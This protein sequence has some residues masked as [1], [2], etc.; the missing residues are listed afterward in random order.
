M[1]TDDI[2]RCLKKLRLNS[3]I[4]QMSEKIEAESNQEY[5][6]K[7][8][9]QEVGRREEA[10]RQRLVKAAGFYTV[11]AFEAFRFDEVTLPE[12][13]TPSYLKNL[14]FLKTGTNIVMYGNVGT[15]YDKY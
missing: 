15:G 8:L 9:E 6:L 7:L 12:Q 14:E 2:L 4:G 3:H 5:L 10:K 11:K 13:V 1:F